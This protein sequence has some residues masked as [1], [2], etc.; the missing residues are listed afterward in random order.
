[1]RLLANGPCLWLLL[2][3]ACGPRAAADGLIVRA[4]IHDQQVFTARTDNGGV[5]VGLLYADL[6]DGSLRTAAWGSN[7]GVEKCLAVPAAK[8][9]AKESLE[10]G[11]EEPVHTFV[12]RDDNYYFVT[13][14]GKLYVAAKPP[15][16]NQSRRLQ[17]IW[18][19]PKQPITHVLFDLDQSRTFVFGK[20]RN[21]KDDVRFALELAGQRPALLGVLAANLLP[22]VRADEP[23]K[24]AMQYARYLRHT[25]QAKENLRLLM[26]DK[27]LQAALPVLETDPDLDDLL[28]RL[29]KAT[30]LRFR[31]DKNIADHRPLFGRVHLK[32]GTAWLV[33]DLIAKTQLDDGRWSKEGD[34]FVLT[35]R[36]S[37][38]AHAQASRQAQRAV[39]ERHAKERAER[40]ALERAFPLRFDARCLAKLVLTDPRPKLDRLLHDLG[41]VSGL[42]L[43]VADRLTGH[44]P[45]LGHI[46]PDAYPVFALMELVAKRQLEDGR[47]EK[48]EGGYRLNGVSTA[49]AKPA[50]SLWRS[51]TAAALLLI[52]IVT[53]TLAYRYRSYWK[54]SGPPAKAAAPNA[55]TAAP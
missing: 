48:I 12:N 36:E 54:S 39:Q 50:S 25:V 38:S 22:P 4:A 34:G 28:Q 37:T 11:L 55:A 43:V 40:E 20:Q 5:P 7:P 24:T 44:D 32:H 21:R 19:D 45:D 15:A 47:W 53:A 14:A 35:A 31:L 16:K 2:V 51:L 29:A 46:K 13:A 23:L 49:P 30:G 3:L 42:K 6:P 41:D 33:M 18:A 10:V 1:M 8:A 9:G 27:R 26:T 17:E 52:G